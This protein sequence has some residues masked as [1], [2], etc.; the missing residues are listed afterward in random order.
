MHARAADSVRS[1]PRLHRTRVYPS[2]ATLDRPKLDISDFGWRDR[3]GAC[4][5]SRGHAEEFIRPRSLPPQPSPACGGGSR[6]TSPLALIPTHTNDFRLA[7][8]QSRSL[9]LSPRD[10]VK[11]RA[12]DPPAPAAI[13]ADR[14]P[15]RVR[16]LDQRLVVSRYRKRRVMKLMAANDGA[17]RPDRTCC[18]KT[19]L[20]VS[21]MQLALGETRGV[22]EQPRHR[23]ARAACIL[24]S[25]AEHYMAAALAVHRPRLR[26]T[27]EPRLEFLR[28]SER[29]GMKLRITAG[30][31]A[32]IAALG[33]R[34]IG[35]RGK[36][37]DLRAGF[38]P[39]REQMRIDERER[40]VRGERN[41]LPGR[42]QRGDG[43]RC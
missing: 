11:E 40:R 15:L 29:A 19:R 24:Q 20:A 26:E 7:C 8:D 30:Q 33:R 36:G 18:A 27:R 42:R 32:D 1:L 34:L 38:A 41:A 43:I 35:E 2:S 12:G 23:V 9:A 28:S 17:R 22:S 3:E 21:K 10:R 16:K 4:N 14:P 31:P 6:P 39:R 5:R 37:H 13:G 25:L